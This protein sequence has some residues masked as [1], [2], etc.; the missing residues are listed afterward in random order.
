MLRIHNRWGLRNHT[1]ARKRFTAA[2]FA[3]AAGLLLLAAPQTGF[4]A[5]TGD[6]SAADSAPIFDINCAQRDLELLTLIERNGNG[7]LSAT[8]TLVEASD[9]L[10]TARARPVRSGMSAMR[11]R[12]TDTGL[13]R[14]ENPSDIARR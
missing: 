10:Y 13:R 5:N 12:S 9:Y 3:V 2:A 4:A 7:G 6:G 1:P 14:L 11:W 8:A